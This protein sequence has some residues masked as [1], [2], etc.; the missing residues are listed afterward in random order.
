MADKVMMAIRLTA[1]ASW[2]IDHR[3]DSALSLMRS[4]VRDQSLA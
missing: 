3:A 4:V 1:S 2:W